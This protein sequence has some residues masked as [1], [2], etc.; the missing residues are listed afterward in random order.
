[1]SASSRARRRT[2]ALLAASLGAI[3]LLAPAT[4]TGATTTP[5][6]RGCTIVGT[7][8]ADVLRGT[9]RAD[10]IC[11]LGGGDTIYG[12]VGDDVLL[13]GAGND[14]LLGGAGDDLLIGGPGRDRSHGG[15]GR[16]IVRDRPPKN[17]RN[18]QV[19][20]AVS[21][22]VPYGTRI[23]WKIL[24]GECTTREYEASFVYDH[25]T[26]PTIS[27]F[28]TA[29]GD[30]L[31]RCGYEKSFV[32]YNVRFETPEGA[33]KDVNVNVK[34]MSAPN[35]YVRSFGVV[36]EQQTVRCEGTTDSVV[37]EFGPVPTPTVTFGPIYRPEPEPAEPPKLDCKDSISVKA[38]TPL[39]D[40]PV[41]TSTGKPLPVLTFNGVM[42]PSITAS[43]LTPTSPSVVLNGSFPS[44]KKYAL[45]VRGKVANPPSE[46]EETVLITANP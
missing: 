27:P 9:D 20:V 6:P 12:R 13:G 5:A 43:R 24:N 23:T 44:A 7:P 41:C 10:V 30:G 3:L 16:D 11:G 15:A 46:E 21:Y 18:F 39:K 14:R 33:N 2:V 37:A 36:C 1:L 17:N 26:L 31:E 34:Q 8:G 40:L 19:N 35:I 32:R 38:N 29:L 28:Y 45:I 25:A 22:N 4:G 42:P